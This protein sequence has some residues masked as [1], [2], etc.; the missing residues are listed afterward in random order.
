M[1]IL[2]SED[3]FTS[4]A[5][6]AGVLKKGGYDVMETTNGN[7]AWLV[8]QQPDAPKLVILDWIMPEM[9][10]PTL[11]QKVRALQ[12]DCPPY[13]LMLTAKREKPDIISGLDAGAN[14]YLGKPF[15][16]D[17]L[18]ARVEVGQR[19]VEMQL[20]LHRQRA[21][22]QR[23]RVEASQRL[24]ELQ[25]A[26]AAKGDELRQSQADLQVMTARLHALREEERAS[27]CRELHDA[28]GLPLSTLHSGV[29]WLESHLQSHKD[30]SP[31][32]LSDKI[33]VMVPLVT[34]LTQQMQ[35]VY[36]SLRPGV[37]FERGLV[38][39]IQWQAQETD[40]HSTLKCTTSLPSEDIPL[41]PNFALAL[42]WIVQE[43]LTNVGRHAQAT[44]VDIRLDCPDS[45]LDLCIQDNG[46]GFPPGLLVGSRT[47]GLLGI[48]Q[49]VGAFGGTAEF[50]NEPGK[51]ATLRLHCP[52]QV[53]PVH[54]NP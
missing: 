3:D 32:L 38:A 46:R 25:D 29:L 8:L 16:P 40:K 22:A 42:F 15:D 52:I 44:Q 1:Q 21:N 49:R 18:L 53:P 17:E 27:I 13:I 20:R 5:V 34:Q 36:A 19:M 54:A 6:L 4:R 45:A 12:T 47:L 28:L 43:A 48:R 23:Y 9:D 10:G 51:G 26:L 50:F 39:A 24:T 33:A 11:L 7:E 2:I 14:D 31:A 41:D 30:P 37:L 35:T